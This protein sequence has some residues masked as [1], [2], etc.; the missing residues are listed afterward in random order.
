MEIDAVFSG[1]GVKGLALIGALEVLEKKGFTFKRLAG[2]SVGSIFAG[3]K[4]AGYTSSEMKQL[5]DATDLGGFLDPR[6]TFL[7]MPLAKWLLLYWR[8]G[9]Y[10]G[11]EFEE[12]LEKKLAAKGVYTFKDV[13]EGSLY[14]MASDLSHNRLVVLP[15]D[16]ENYGIPPQT[17]PVARAIRMSCSIPYFFEPVR[18]RSLEGTS[19]IVDGGV[20]SNFPMW[21]FVNPEE[22]RERPVLGITLSQ[23]KFEQL[24]ANIQNAIQLFDALFTTMKDAHDARYISRKLEKDIIFIPTEGILSIDFKLTDEK[25]AAL[26]ESGRKK[27]EAFLKTWTY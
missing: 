4:A 9:L 1:G 11:A 10:R 27:T 23:K 2:T 15:D 19:I 25:K 8:L 20:L 5:L 3:L 26:I 24:K 17:F 16:L 12:W 14:F 7:P 18:L 22:K 6:K 21:L 13:P